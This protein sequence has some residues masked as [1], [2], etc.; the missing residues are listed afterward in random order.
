MPQYLS[1]IVNSSNA[2]AP[3]N[4]ALVLVASLVLPP[5]QWMIDGEGWINITSGTPAIQLV[6]AALSIGAPSANALNEPDINQSVN[7]VTLSQSSSAKSTAGFVLPLNS[8]M[9]VNND[10]SITAELSIRV[11]WSSTGTFA[12][13]GKISGRA[14][15]P[16][17]YIPAPLR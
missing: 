17:T 5:G 4:G 16:P 8:M 13:Y 6:A 2:V 3:V 11:D 14:P 9:E 12:L 15:D 1:T 10:N 7:V